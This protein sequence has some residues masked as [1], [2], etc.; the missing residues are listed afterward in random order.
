M[1]QSGFLGALFRVGLRLR[2]AS[3]AVIAFSLAVA[4]SAAQTTD[5]PNNGPG[6]QGNPKPIAA[7]SFAQTDG[8]VVPDASRHGYD[9]IIYG[10]PVLE[11]RWGK[12][13]ALAFDG[14]GDNSFWQ[15]G[16][17][18]CGLGVS[19][20]LTQAFTQLSI[21]AW[22]RKNPTWWM[23]IVYRD[24]WDNPSGFGLYTEWSAG[25]V[26]FG[27]YDS[28]GNHSQVQ[29]ET[30]VQDGQWH[31][32]V[33]TMEPAGDCGYIYRIYVDGKL[34][35]D[36]VGTLAVGEAPAGS[37]ILKIAY[38]NASGADGVFQ[39]ALDGIAIYDVALTP[40]Q[41][42]ARFESTRQH[43]SKPLPNGLSEAQSL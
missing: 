26:V 41:V 11:P 29:S 16:A 27:H 34:D 31:H 21:E 37:G 7:W 9:A 5:N 12:N 13:V 14:T 38:P 43:P 2:P 39:G 33:G 30:V 18:N 20:P 1:N 6:R 32:V 40:A 3:F 36:Q 17:Q 8:N 10:Q 42:K 25:K 19:K 22:V 24:L 15:G 23:P 4:I 35:A 28:T